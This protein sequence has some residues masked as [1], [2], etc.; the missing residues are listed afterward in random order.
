VALAGKFIDWLL[1]NA[2]Y[3][4]VL[5]AERGVSITALCAPQPD[6]RPAAHSD[7]LRCF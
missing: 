1:N 3:T 4:S 5:N 6:N 2:V 7:T